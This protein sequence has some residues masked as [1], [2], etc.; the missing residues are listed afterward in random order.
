MTITINEA[1]S[2][3]EAIHDDRK[4]IDDLNDDLDGQQALR[5]GIEALKLIK[6]NR[7]LVYEMGGVS[8]GLP[9]EKVE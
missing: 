1:I 4:S 2:F 3:L 8:I 6:K 7:E 9:G 5:L